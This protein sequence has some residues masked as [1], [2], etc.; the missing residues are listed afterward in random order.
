VLVI[1]TWGISIVARRAGGAGS[2][3]TPRSLFDEVF[4]IVIH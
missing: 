2:E 1:Y 3:P 4:S